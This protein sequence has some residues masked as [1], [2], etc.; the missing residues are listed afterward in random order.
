MRLTTA[1]FLLA[2]TATV[3]GQAATDTYQDT[4]KLPDFEW[5][6]YGTR[7]TGRMYTRR[8]AI[9]GD[10]LFASGYLK[11][12]NAPN[13]E[14]FVDVD[15]DFGVTGPYTS[16]DPTGASAFSITSDLISY[17]TEYGSFAQ[18]EVGV[19]KINRLTGRPEDV[20]VYYGEGQDETT[21]LAAKTTDNGENLLAI[22]GHFVGTLRADHGDGTSTT[23][24]NSNA[25]GG[26]DYVQHPNAVKNGYDDGFVILA[27]ADTGDAKWAVAYPKSTKDAET[28]GVD[29]DAEGNIYGAGY[30]CNTLADETV[31]CN[32]FV[33]KFGA[34]DGNIVWE[35]EFTDLGAA[36]WLVYDE[37]DDSLYVTGTT[38]YRGEVDDS[39]EH[40]WCNTVT[41]AITMRLSASNGDIDWIRSIEGS[42]RWNFFDQ[43]GDIR[44]AHESDGPYI[45]VALDDAGEEGSVT[46]DGGTHYS[47][48]LSAD[49]TLTPE[50]EIDTTKLVTEADCPSGSSFVSRTS[51]NGFAASSAGTG[52]SCGNGEEAADA[53]V[54]KYHKYTGLPIWANDVPPVASL[55]PHSDGKSVMVIGFYYPDWG[56]F[57]SVVL[58]NYNGV[59][60]AYNAK[61]DAVTG[62]GVYVMHSGGVNKDRPYDAVGDDNGDIYMVGYTQSQVI[63]WGGTLTTKIIE[64]GVDQNDDAGTAF[65]MGNVGGKTSEYQFFAVK[66]R[67]SEEG[68]TQSCVETCTSE[69]GIATKSIDS[70]SCLI[71]NHCFVAGATSE[72]FGRPCLVCNPEISQ[73]AWSYG[74]TLGIQDCLIE[75]VCREEGQMLT[76]RESR[77]VTHTSKCQLCSPTVDF[78]GWSV[79]P[80][81]VLVPDV[82]PPND[83][84]NKT[85]SPTKAPVRSPV[86]AP[87]TSPV[88]SG[89]DT[90]VDPILCMMSTLAIA[91]EEIWDG[92]EGIDMKNAKVCNVET[93]T[94]DLSGDPSVLDNISSKCTE[95]KVI[96]TDMRIC[97][98]DLID[99]ETGAGPGGNIEVTNMPICMSSI[100]PDDT[101]LKNLLAGGVLQTLLGG[102]DDV[103]GYIELTPKSFLMDECPAVVDKSKVNVPEDSHDHDSH[104]HGS[105]DHDSQD[106]SDAFCLRAGSIVIASAVIIVSLLH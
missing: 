67:S 97:E 86:A 1:S 54:M 88:S 89:G 34:D 55:V 45:Y 41:C 18:Y 16:A 33:A 5:A 95:G 98:I 91:S 71:D 72:I 24:F 32:G 61:I 37:T 62:K 102:L 27:D 69:D 59:E 51:V 22:S 66:L 31:L 60:G 38:S 106:E 87:V 44:L 104:D 79:D 63:S 35:K 92:M 56:H 6:A 19:V 96:E 57:D 49:G 46:L 94:C 9:L 21:G 39:K 50:Y 80:D 76:Y 78:L 28:V 47:G 84:L 105:K 81:F 82:N 17:T 65:Q 7:L 83:C 52:V 43:S 4:C 26:S 30:S 48:C 74:P 53:C 99:P 68:N 36:M 11:S 64:E 23:L 3:T 12:T 8:A 14:G 70:N 20:Y 10:S 25:E 13:V 42:P 73:T 29:L 2:T 58:P 93:M 100:C 101:S 75:N 85:E 90:N 103:E 77:R 40:D 15:D